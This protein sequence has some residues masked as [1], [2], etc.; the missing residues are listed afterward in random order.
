MREIVDAHHHLWDRTALPYPW[1]EGPPYGPS[2]AGDVGPIS[3]SYLLDDFR[4]DT[5][6]Y[7]LTGSVHVD[8]GT[9]DRIGETAWLQ[10]I[11]DAEGLPTAIVAGT[12]LHDPDIDSV[13]AR[14]AAFGAIRGIRHILNWDPDPNLTFTD[15]PDLMTDAHWLR[16]Y[17]ALARHDFSFDLQVYP[18]QLAGAAALAAKFPDTPIILNH[19]GMPL[20]QRDMGLETWK[21]GMRALAAQPNA[22]VKVS[23]LAWWTGTGPSTVSGRSSSRRSTPLA[24]TGAC[25][26]RT[27]P[28]TAST[29]RSPRSTARS[30]PSSPTSA[31]TSSTPCSP[32]TR[33]GSTG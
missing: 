3:K 27:S 14:H 6:G 13:L 17:A 5:A 33:S 16:G 30:R 28:S 1:L 7:H 18:W 22:S 20:H 32:A 9:S 15:R 29:A 19:A 8:G 4:A 26:P 21:A 23:G 2:V 10:A 24:P 11:A 25:L 12:Q 31:P